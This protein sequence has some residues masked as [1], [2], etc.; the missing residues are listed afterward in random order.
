MP[1]EEDGVVFEP[2][3]G[4]QGHERDGAARVVEFVGRRDERDLGEEVEQG[5]LRV[6]GVELARLRQELFDVLGARLVLRVAACPQQVDVAGA[7]EDLLEDVAGT[8]AVAVDRPAGRPRIVEPREVD[9]GL[10]TFGPSPSSSAWRSESRRVCSCLSAWSCSAASVAGPMPRLGTFMMRRSAI[11]S[12]GLATCDEVRHDVFDLGALV[13]LGAAEHPVRDGGTDE[14]LFQRTGLRVGAVE[15]GDVLVGEPG[16]VQ[17][18]DLVG[19]ELR[20]VV[21]AVPGE[22]G[23]LLALADRS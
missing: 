16:L 15:D 23:D 4:V 13:E 7:V 14:D 5:A 8:F 10:R 1:G 6:A 11:G 20:L 12:A 19:D 22:A 21:L 2:L 17:R 3:R 9:H 18:R